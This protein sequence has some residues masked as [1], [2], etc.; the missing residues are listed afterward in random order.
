MIRLSSFLSRMRG[1]MTGRFAR[2]NREPPS[3]TAVVHLSLYPYSGYM[4][5]M[6]IYAGP[7]PYSL[8]F[9]LFCCTSTIVAL[10]PGENF[11][12]HVQ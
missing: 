12:Y 2:G 11:H 10:G 1:K 7:H 8:L 4:L 5:F 9:L 3:V 6:H